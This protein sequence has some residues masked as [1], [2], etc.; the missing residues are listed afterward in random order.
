MA[1]H[2]HLS[3]ALWNFEVT[4]PQEIMADMAEA[5]DAA[6]KRLGDNRPAALP[7]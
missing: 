7:K 6:V 3:R 4:A 5:A 2:A 1:A